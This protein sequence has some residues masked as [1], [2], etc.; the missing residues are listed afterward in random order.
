LDAQ[1][2]ANKKVAKRNGDDTFHWTNCAP[3][4][5]QLNQGRKRWLGLEDYVIA[6]FAK[7][8]GRACVVN[9]PVFDAPLSHKAEGGHVVPDL[10]GKRH[11]DPTFGGV[12][13]PKLFFKVI[14]CEGEDGNLKVAAFLMSQEDFL[15]TMGSRLK[16]M[17]PIEEEILTPAEARLYQIRLKDL[18]ELTSLD[19]GP[20]VEFDT[21]GVVEE[22]TAAK[23]PPRVIRKFEDIVV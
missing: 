1:W 9:G 5:W 12:P 8:T 7:D 15:Q 6:T 10:D 20:L 13:I 22:A 21:S 16:G 17:P 2:G 4:H 18:E 14:A 19:F 11:K 3:Q 23:G